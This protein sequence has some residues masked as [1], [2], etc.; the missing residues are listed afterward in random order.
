MFALLA[1]MRCDMAQG[2]LIA[3]PCPASELLTILND[4]RRMEF[5]QNTAAAALTQV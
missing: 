2:Y 1:T 5:Y 3:R 4:T